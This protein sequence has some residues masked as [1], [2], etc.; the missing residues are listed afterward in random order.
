MQRLGYLIP[1]YEVINFLP[2]AGPTCHLPISSGH[3]HHQTCMNLAQHQEMNQNI[4]TSLC[5]TVCHKAK[6]MC[7][8]SSGLLGPMHDID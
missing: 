8:G 3:S 1:E 7:F 4:G 2:V 5:P 6:Q